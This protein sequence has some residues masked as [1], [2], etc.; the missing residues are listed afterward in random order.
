MSVTESEITHSQ[1]FDPSDDTV[2]EIVARHPN[3]SRVFQEHGIQFCCQG[4]KTL[5][6]AC[7]KVGISL[8]SFSDGLR[9]ELAR[10][11]ASLENP[12]EL[13]LGELAE[14]IVTTH[15][16]F[17]RRELP[18]LHEM[19][20]RV[21]RVH[22]GHT[23]SLIEVFQVFAEMSHEL[24]LH[25]QKEETVLFPVIRDIDSGADRTGGMLGGAIHCMME[26]HDETVAA[27]ERLHDLT[28]GFD[29]P[30]DACNTYRALF[31]GLADLERDTHQHIHLEN[32]VLFP[33]A[34][35]LAG[36]N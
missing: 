25:A 13:P 35:A 1:P 17:L 8:E 9:V 15:H 23:P 30:V 24:A 33:R 20:E 31:A 36:H 6:E 12:A 28:G 34:V 16:G 26:E 3:L 22:G 19:A 4:Q 21:A 29:P 7:E 5:S 18:R 11:P 10:Q 14:Y 32:N 2:G 27:L